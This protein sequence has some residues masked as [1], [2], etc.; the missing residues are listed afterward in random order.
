[1]FFIDKDKNAM[2]KKNNENIDICADNQNILEKW[3][4]SKIN[5]IIT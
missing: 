1:M 3:V 2:D 4:G 5:K